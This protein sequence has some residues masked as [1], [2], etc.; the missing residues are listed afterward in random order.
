MKKRLLVIVLLACT[1]L[2]VQSVSSKEACG[3]DGPTYIPLPPTPDPIPPITKPTPLS[4]VQDVEA[5][6]YEGVLSIVFNNDLGNADITVTN[7]MTGEMWM[8]SVN[9]IGVSSIYLSDSAGY[10]TIYVTTDD[11]GYSGAFMLE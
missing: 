6:Y 4:L 3:G 8:D 9:G 2:M 11:G 1:G 10:Y 5:T 7:T